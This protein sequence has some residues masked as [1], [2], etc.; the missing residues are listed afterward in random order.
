[1][2][3]SRMTLGAL[4]TL[5]LAVPAMAEDT[6]TPASV[7]TA[8]Q[9]CRTERDQMGKATFAQTY[10]TNKTRSN[11]FG[12]SVSKR[13]AKTEA[14]AEEAHTNASKQCDA[15]EAADPAAFKAKYGTGKNGSNAHGK[16]VSGKAK[17]ETAATVEEQTDADVSAA[18]SCKA[19]RKADPAAFKAKYGT[20]AN[21]SNAFGKCVSAQAKAQNDDT[22]S[23]ST[24]TTS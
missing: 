15:E 16:C 10:G 12:K 4:V 5:A 11:A 22:P 19:E 6:T 7:P 1:M 17:A 14:A 13:T 8:E 21:K 24:T 18:K 20:N 3:T 2:T 9:Q 23:E